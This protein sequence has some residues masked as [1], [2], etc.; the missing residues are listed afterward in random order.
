MSWS[1][2]GGPGCKRRG[3]DANRAPFQAYGLPCFG[4]RASALWL[5]VILICVVVSAG[6]AHGADEELGD[7]PD[8]FDL[9]TSLDTGT[10]LASYGLVFVGLCI[11]CRAIPDAPLLV[12]LVSMPIVQ[13]TG[14]RVA[15][16]VLQCVVVW[17][18]AGTG[19]SLVPSWPM[20]VFLLCAVASVGWALYPAEALFRES[21]GICPMLLLLPLMIATRALLHAELTTAGRLLWA[22]TLGCVPGC[23]LTIANALAGVVYA[24]GGEGYYMGFVRPDVFSPML[25][26]SGLFLLLYL[27][28]PAANSKT[29]M[30]AGL[31]LPVICLALVLSGIR[32]GWVAFA[33]ATLLLV[34]RMRSF[35]AVAGLIAVIT[36]V[37]IL[38]FSGSPRLNVREKLA[39][40]LSEQSLQ[41]GEQRVAFWE[42]A[43]QGF[44]RRPVL[45]IGW[46]SFP[47]FA[48]DNTVGREVATHNIFVR[49][50]CELG[51][52]GL[53]VFLIWIMRS[54]LKARHTSEGVLVGVL[55]AGV[56]AQGFFLD[57]F[58]CAYFWLFLGVSDGIQTL[59]LTVGNELGGAYSPVLGDRI[60]S[61]I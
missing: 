2:L 34:P 42:V 37:I 21:T 6:V 24:D 30:V 18:K 12:Y 53:M 32:S 46:G 29:R 11:L 26:M 36:A 56:L 40:R 9:V 31:L 35:T 19:R 3:R 23:F 4:W 61:A 33:L 54:L 45:G 44:I 39:A 7:N 5:W 58:V 50:L 52:V 27:T 41:T 16:M 59:G 55:M 25:V 60:P 57:H 14:F 1:F 48:A 28:S 43:V 20:G 38:V 10:R 8:V 22:L 47:A 51:S 49:I 15:L 17:A 13:F